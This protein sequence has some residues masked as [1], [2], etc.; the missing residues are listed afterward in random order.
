MRLRDSLRSFAVM[1]SD[2]DGQIHYMEFA[3]YFGFQQQSMGGRSPAER[4]PTR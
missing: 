3:K 1:D 2:G 4:G